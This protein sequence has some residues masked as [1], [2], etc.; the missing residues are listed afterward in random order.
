MTDVQEPRLLIEYRDADET[1]PLQR[2]R[3]ETLWRRIRDAQ[4]AFDL[5]RIP[6]DAEPY[7]TVLSLHPRFEVD[8]QTGTLT[9]GESPTGSPLVDADAGPDEQAT[10]RDEPDVGD[11]LCAYQASVKVTAKNL[12]SFLCFQPLGCG[13]IQFSPEM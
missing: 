2:D 4:G 9:E 13:E 10:E 11:T 7:A 12:I 3:F 1:I 6:P 5:D 8:E